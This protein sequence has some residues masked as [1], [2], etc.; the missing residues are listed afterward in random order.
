MIELLSNNFLKHFIYVLI[1]GVYY[2]E[3]HVS[4][5][6]GCVWTQSDA[7]SFCSMSDCTNHMAEAVWCSIKDLLDYLIIDQQK[8]KINI[9]SDSPSSQ[10]RN[11]TSI[12]FLN[13][14][15]TK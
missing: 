14:Y 1:I 9:I 11:K 4:L 8:K 12:Y 7:F 15:A 13:Q 5:H 3:H 10:Y 6:S 2:N